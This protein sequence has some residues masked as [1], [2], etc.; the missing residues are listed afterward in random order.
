MANAGYLT[1]IDRFFVRNHAPTPRVD[2]RLAASREGPGVERTLE[3]G[4]DDLTRLPGISVVR[5]L[6]CAGNGRVFFEQEREVPGTPWRLGAIVVAEWAGVRLREIL[7]RAGLKLRD[8]VQGRLR[9]VRLH[10]RVCLNAHS[11]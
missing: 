5:A 8:Q 10:G 1:P 7:E 9:D 2:R 3:L 11:M 6:G 4:Y